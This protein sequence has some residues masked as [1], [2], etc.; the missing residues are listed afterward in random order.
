M[1]KPIAIFDAGLGSYA[2]VETVHKAYPKQD[3]I[4]FADRKN[5][6]YGKKTIEVL[7]VIIENSINFLFE[8]GANF[9]I[10]ASN[11]P[12]ITVLDKI[13]NK[14][15]VIGI[16]PPIA[17]VI[18]DGKKN[19]LIIGA[20]VMTES[21]EMKEFI[22]KEAGSF[23][24]QFHSKNASPLIELIESGDFINKKDETETKIKN[25]MVEA[26]NEFGKIDSITLSSTH[27]PWLKNYFEKLFPEIKLYDPASKLIKAIEP[28]ITD[29]MGEIFS[30]ITESQ[31]YPAEEFLKTLDILNIK[32]N[33]RIHN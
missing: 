11:A 28:Y 18:E 31:E 22:K 17:D 26:E 6:P 33:Y 23:H 13:K 24:E 4:Y 19:T 15:K 29:G 5:F 1:N 10:L 2:I 25:F 3:I 14:E 12:S 27:L 32:L 7:K 20:K 30:I 9:I 21:K 16:Y 8:E